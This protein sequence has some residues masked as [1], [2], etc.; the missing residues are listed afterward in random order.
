MLF[1]S[2][3][4]YGSSGGVGV[5]PLA[6]AFSGDEERDG[7]AA[8]GIG[9][10]DGFDVAMLARCGE[11]G[12][13]LYAGADD[14]RGVGLFRRAILGEYC[15]V[16]LILP[17]SLGEGVPTGV[18]GKGKQRQ[19]EADR[20]KSKTDQEARIKEG[21]LRGWLFFHVVLWVE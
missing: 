2:A 19:E 11:A 12:D 9:R 8:Q 6:A 4:A 3:W 17:F 15:G 16:R 13:A 21:R 5:L 10:A 14:S 7:L 18:E 1:R 20:A